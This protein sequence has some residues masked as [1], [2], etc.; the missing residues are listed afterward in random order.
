MK[1]A[2]ATKS[3]ASRTEIDVKVAQLGSPVTEVTITK[4]GTVADA[5]K[6]A[7]VK[8]GGVTVKCAGRKVELDDLPDHGDRLTI[9][10]PVKGAN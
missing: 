5:L 2:K 3:R 1:K 10:D 7:G 4:G 9:S 6:A 8:T